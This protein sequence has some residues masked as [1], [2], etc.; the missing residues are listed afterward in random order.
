M[1]G[2]TEGVLT[3][4]RGVFLNPGACLAESGHL[5]S[6]VTRA[7]R[8]PSG[9][10]GVDGGHAGPDRHMDG[11]ARLGQGQ[12]RRQLAAGGLQLGGGQCGHVVLTH[13]R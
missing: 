1:A 13:Q 8:R 6:R 2:P 10:F 5:G 3:R 11:G 4:C 7:G 12:A 9:Q